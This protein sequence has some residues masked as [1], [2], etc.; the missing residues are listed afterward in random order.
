MSKYSPYISSIGISN[1]AGIPGIRGI[2]I[3]YD[4]LC[5]NYDQICETLR[6]HYM[7]VA[8][9]YH[10]YDF[11]R[12]SD[13]RVGK[14]QIDMAYRMG[15]KRILVVPGF[16]EEEDARTLHSVSNDYFDCNAA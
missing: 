6:Y 13:I 5:A 7:E 1:C 4:Q 8:S 10:F 11:Q 15:V 14:D 3:E 12:K 16:L 9:I 2:D